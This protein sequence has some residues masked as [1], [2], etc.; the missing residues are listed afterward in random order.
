MFGLW[1]RIKGFLAHGPEN[2]WD[3]GDHNICEKAISRCFT[4]N[5][6]ESENLPLVA[7]C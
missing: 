2:G 3:V 1:D 5:F 6:A 4:V 7:L